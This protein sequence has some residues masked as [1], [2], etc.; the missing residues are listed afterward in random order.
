[1][2]SLTLATT[3]GLAALITAAPALAVRPSRPSRRRTRPSPRP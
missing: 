1:M 2:R 3:L